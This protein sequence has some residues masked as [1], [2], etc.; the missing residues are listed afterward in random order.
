MPRAFGEMHGRISNARASFVKNKLVSSDRSSM[1]PTRANNNMTG[2][3][4]V[5]NLKKRK[6]S[7]EAEKRVNARMSDCF[8]TRGKDFVDVL[9]KKQA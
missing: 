7:S 5:R 3:S 8:N 9:I 2:T 4:R 6:R 1:K